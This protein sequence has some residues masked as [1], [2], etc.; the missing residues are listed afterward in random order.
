[1]NE[2]PECRWAAPALGGKRPCTSLKVIAPQGVTPEICHGC[3]LRNHEPPS[4]PR[5]ELPCVH[6]GESTGQLLECP[7]CTG[8]IR[9]KVFA[10]SVWGVCTPVKMVPGTW[11]C[12][13][14]PRY[15]AKP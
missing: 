5:K 12:K 4:P 9:V 6:L 2:F 10:C 1:M 7:S 11:C 8:G 3:T 14:C 15:E 13:H